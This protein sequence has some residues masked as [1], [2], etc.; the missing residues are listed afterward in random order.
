MPF[1]KIK[2]SLRISLPNSFGLSQLFG[3]SYTNPVLSFRF[4]LGYFFCLTTHFL[5]T[6][7]NSFIDY[8]SCSYSSY[9]CADSI[10][11]HYFR[12]DA[13]LLFFL[14]LFFLTQPN[15]FLILKLVLGNSFLIESRPGF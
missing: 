6:K 9:F 8:S 1:H 13:T 12:Q 15:V 3:V 14:S 11:L 7:K 10:A 2:F 4:V 5:K